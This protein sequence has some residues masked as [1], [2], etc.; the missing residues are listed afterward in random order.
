[1]LLRAWVTGNSCTTYLQVF[2]FTTGGRR[3]LSEHQVT[4]VHL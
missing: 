4:R 3:N 2:Y 1:V